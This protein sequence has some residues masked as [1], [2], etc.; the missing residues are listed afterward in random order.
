VYPNPF[1][2]ATTIRFSLDSQSETIIQIYTL[3][4]RIVKTL[5][6]SVFSA[7]HHEI[8]WNGTNATGMPVPSGIYMVKIET[9]KFSSTRKMILLK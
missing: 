9:E 6:N 2:P 4:G 7:G 3:T 5:A 8:K 1:N